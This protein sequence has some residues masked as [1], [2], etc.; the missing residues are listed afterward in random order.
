MPYVYVV[1]NTGDGN[2]YGI[3]GSAKK[4]CLAVADVGFEVDVEVDTVRLRRG[5]PMRYTEIDSEY[6]DDFTADR[7]LVQ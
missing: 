5:E 6:V 1:F 2:I 7:V 4:A 3:Y